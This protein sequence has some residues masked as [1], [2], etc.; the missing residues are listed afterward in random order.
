M[1]RPSWNKSQAI[2]QVISLKALLE[3]NEDSGAG[4]LRKIVASPHNDPPRVTFFAFRVKITVCLF[5]GTCLIP[6]L[7][8]RGLRSQPIQ[9][10]KPVPMSRFLRRPKNRCRIRR[11]NR[12]NRFTRTDRRMRFQRPLVPP[13]LTSLSASFA[14]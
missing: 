4:V 5:Y 7:L 1:R 10:R 3:P 2:Q 13:G 8:S 6:N 12:K 11:K 14:R 9:L